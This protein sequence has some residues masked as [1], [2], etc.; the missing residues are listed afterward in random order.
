MKPAQHAQL[1]RAAAAFGIA[2]LSIALMSPVAASAGERAA[3]KLEQIIALEEAASSLGRYRIVFTTRAPLPTPTDTFP[4]VAVYLN[5]LPVRLAPFAPAG[6]EHVGYVSALPAGQ[7]VL[8]A[9]GLDARRPIESEISVDT[10][11]LS[12]SAPPRGAYEA[13]H[14]RRSEAAPNLA[15]LWNSAESVFVGV[16]VR[17]ESHPAS[18][19]HWR[20]YFKRD[21]NLRGA[22]AKRDGA[23]ATADSELAILQATS[24]G[25]SLELGG[26]YLVFV[27]RRSSGEQR[28]AADQLTADEFSTVRI[29]WPSA[30]PVDVFIRE[31]RDLIA[32]MPGDTAA[33]RRLREWLLRE[34]QSP[35][36]EVRRTAAEELGRVATGDQKLNEDERRQLQPRLAAEP[37]P[38]AKD[39]LRTLLA[40]P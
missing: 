30:D 4:G 37:S 31:Y 38:T 13:P 22:A 14:I 40:A 29:W 8:R 33:R 35:S 25:E 28:A 26:R 15:A 17:R 34:L 19:L 27:T 7:S 10:T 18:K 20:L 9:T 24:V 3:V 39:A 11:I 12:K 36:P 5:D 32:A 21:E 6:T 16:L 2:W 1:N 23:A